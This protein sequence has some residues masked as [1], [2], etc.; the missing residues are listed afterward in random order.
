MAQFSDWISRLF[1]S[2]P[3]RGLSG[4]VDDLAMDPRDACF[5]SRLRR[6]Q[7]AE[8][9]IED[10]FLLWA[11]QST[12]RKRMGLREHLTSQKA[13]G[14]ADF[15]DVLVVVNDADFRRTFNRVSEPWEHQA[16]RVLTQEFENFCRLEGYDL[17]FT[18]RGIRVRILHDGGAEMQ[19]NSFGLRRGEYVTG[20]LPNLYTG[21]ASSSRPIISILLN[22]PDAW[23]GYREVG[24]MFSDQVQFTLG[25]H[26][27]DNFA[28]PNLQEPALYRL[29]QYLDGSFV[30]IINPDLQ[31]RF[32]VSSDESG[33]AS[34]LVISDAESNV[35]AY[36]VLAQLESFVTDAPY[37]DSE[38]VSRPVPLSLQP[39]ETDFPP[40]DPDLTQ[41]ATPSMPRPLPSQ[42]F[43]QKTIVPDSVHERLLTLRERG[44]LLQ[45][46]HFRKFMQGYDVYISMQGTVSTHRADP[47]ATL[48]VRDDTV[49]LVVHKPDVTVNGL[50]VTVDSPL[51]LYDRT[52]IQVGP[53][54]LEYNDLSR[55]RMDGWPY[56]G[57]ILRNASS[58]H[59][60]FGGRYRIG[61]DRRSKVQLPD[62]P[63]NENIVWL[64]S[65]VDGATIRARSG[66]IP[67]SRFYT[68]SIMV[69]S[70]HVEIDLQGE[71]TLNAIAQHCYTYV[72]RG[73]EILALPP[74]KQ[75][76]AAAQLELKAGDDL[77][78]GNCL[79]QVAFQ[80]I[81][82]GNT[83][84]GFAPKKIT[85][86]SLAR[87]MDPEPEEAE[88]GRKSGMSARERLGRVISTPIGGV[89]P[90]PKS[91][92]AT[93]PPPER[94]PAPTTTRPPIAELRPPDARPAP[95]EARPAPRPVED[96]R[97]AVKPLEPVPLP[98]KAPPV[99]PKPPAAP[100]EASDIPAAAGL[101]ERGPAPVP[102]KM[103]TPSAD[104]IL[105]I[106]L[107]IPRAPLIDPMSIPP[108]PVTPPPP[109][110][111]PA[112]RAEIRAEPRSSVDS[113]AEA[114]RPLP[115]VVSRPA[116]RPDPLATPEPLAALADEDADTRRRRPPVPAQRGEDFV[117]VVDEKNWNLELG[118]PARLM[119][120]GWAIT[121]EVVIGN[122]ADCAVIIP[123]GRSEPHQM[124]H[125]HEYFSLKVR[126]NRGKAE[127][128]DNVEA[129]LRIGGEERDRVNTL[130]DLELEVLRRDADG[131]VDYSV[132]LHLDPTIPLPDP[133]AQL[134]TVDVRDRRAQALFT[135]GL[136]LGA[137]RAVKLGRIQANAL[138]KANS[139]QLSDYL[140][141]YRQ[142]DGSFLPFFIGRGDVFQTA[143]EDGRPLQL[144]PGDSL[145]VD[146]ALYRFLER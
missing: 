138:Y 123:E 44:A 86:D 45:R 146:T 59:M 10:P 55:V 13:D 31:D 83:S 116:P 126:G 69:A 130:E 24:R 47:A 140:E 64:E 56:L 119:Q 23:E 135:T 1:S 4:D 28:H 20:L 106:D 96:P 49:R 41:R 102:M 105:G 61:R 107:P 2:G 120:V 108:I 80:P 3:A 121:G 53:H 85:A 110:A 87:A 100:V 57:E 112:P 12:T 76:A 132:I 78:V 50:R 136:P 79:F 144:Q 101:G 89:E 142:A 9:I 40:S 22:I 48:Q 122:Y 29:Q 134:L 81:G 104:S 39:A 68:D 95:S 14:P 82:A 84:G 124:F 30:H 51:P 27:L 5:A 115:P 109:K 72:R 129:R 94:P 58:T 37:E 60:V 66:D 128:L 46:V 35:I 33:G 32:S 93:R 141:S 26:W 16:S 15:T 137:V 97:P 18:S 127:L 91:D 8:D 117:S 133:R 7:S 65:A 43:G 38:Q 143:P 54:T 71:P 42:V 62:E 70:E 145:L 114:P 36:M 113:R 6:H 73:G 77:L 34:V 19:G 103:V 139:L 63:H 74:L 99:A 111:E 125:T 21:P 17:L 92:S 52:V 75:G 90:R 118:R 131:E 88:A 25:S 98:A 11:T 67:K